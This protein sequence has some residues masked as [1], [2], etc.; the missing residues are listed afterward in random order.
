M[1]ICGL[2]TAFPDQFFVSFN[3]EHHVLSSN[4]LYLVFRIG[5]EIVFDLKSES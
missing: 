3:I 4:S 5:T 1:S 2:F